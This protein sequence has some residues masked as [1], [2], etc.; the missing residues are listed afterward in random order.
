MVRAWRGLGG[1]EERASLR[2][3]MNYFLDTETL[4]PRFGLPPER[5]PNRAISLRFGADR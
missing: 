5:P 3:A 4:F 1:F 2:T